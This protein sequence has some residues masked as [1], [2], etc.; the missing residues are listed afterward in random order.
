MDSLTAS[1]Q[2][3][4]LALKTHLRRM[5]R[6]G[7]QTVIVAVGQDL[8]DIDVFDAGRWQVIAG[9]F[10]AGCFAWVVTTLAA[11]PQD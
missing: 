2:D 4:W 6:T 3:R 11:P 5:V 10:L 7:A 9:A 8:V 1:P